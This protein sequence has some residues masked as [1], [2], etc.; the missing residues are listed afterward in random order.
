ME[1]KTAIIAK[2]GSLLGSGKIKELEADNRSL[3][4][5]IAAREE[6]IED[7]QASLQRQRAQYGR[8]LATVQ[9]DYIQKL[10]RE[11]ERTAYLQKWTERACGWFPLFA[12]AMRMERYCR[13]QLH[14]RA[15][16]PAFYVPAVGI[17]RELYSEEH[18][19]ALSVTGA[20]AQM[21]IEQGERGNALSCA[22]T[23]RTSLTGSGSS[24]RGCSDEYGQ[25][26]SNR[27]GKTRD[28]NCNDYKYLCANIKN[29]G[30]IIC[31]S[32]IFHI[33]AFEERKLPSRHFRI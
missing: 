22:S 8:E 27:N 15:D 19:R 1:A 13:S 23:G 18:K 29:V 14:A 33:F 7:L 10:E 11:R 6:S 31:A 32:C 12:D 21:G 30:N 28:S 20:T 9:T 16:G 5:E 24:S 17:Q 4:N 3:Q 25:Q 26:C 2:V